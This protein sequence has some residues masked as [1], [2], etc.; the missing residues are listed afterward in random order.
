MP[1]T[2]RS[3]TPPR[4]ISQHTVDVLAEGEQSL[5]DEPIVDAD[6]AFHPARTV[7]GVSKLRENYLLE[8]EVTAYVP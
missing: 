6:A 3:T 1:S 5:T 4:P 8:I 2:D 7:V